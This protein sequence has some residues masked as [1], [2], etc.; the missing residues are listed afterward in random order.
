MSPKYACSKQVMGYFCSRRGSS[1]GRQQYC[2]VS[3]V[4]GP[5]C[6][7][8]F[9]SRHGSCRWLRKTPFLCEVVYFN[10]ILRDYPLIKS[11]LFSHRMLHKALLYLAQAT[12]KVPQALLSKRNAF[13]SLLLDS[14][15]NKATS[16]KKIIPG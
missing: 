1:N 7:V 8:A 10:G 3:D 9:P 4:T 15:R 2:L 5:H 16:K 14:S 6:L 13:F 12:L 11:K